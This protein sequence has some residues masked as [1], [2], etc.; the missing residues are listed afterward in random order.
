M[1]TNYGNKIFISC[2]GEYED[3]INKDCGVVYIVIGTGTE[4]LFKIKKS[5][6]D[7]FTADIKIGILEKIMKYYG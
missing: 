6:W 3:E 1:E 2:D 7:T 5:V 4:E